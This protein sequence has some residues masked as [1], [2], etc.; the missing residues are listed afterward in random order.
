MNNSVFEQ[1]HSYTKYL[2]LDL[3]AQE[4]ARFSEDQALSDAQLQAIASV[5]SYL[6]DKKEENIVATLLRMSRLP[7]KEP[8]TFENFDFSQLHGK[9][10][11]ALKNLSTLSALY[12]HTNLAFIGPQG[13]GKTHLAMA[14]G[15]ACCERGLKAYFLKAT[16]L[17]QRLTEARRHGRENSC[18]NGLV[19]PSCL[20]IDEIGRCVFDR[21]NTRMFFDIID[22]RYNKEG[23]NTLIL[24][25]NK[26]PDKWGEY[27]N[28][29]SSLLCSLYRI[30]DVAT[31]FVIKGNSYRGKQC[32]T[33]ALTAGEPVSVI[34]SKN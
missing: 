9:D 2:D 20:I 22:R 25:S 33:I 1:I 17:N 28:E 11:E 4:I 21:E 14:Y 7:M 12:S 5:F 23:P 10:A 24:T 29:D 19:K 30:F 32:E 8:K 15:R 31:V 27:F 3:G 26:S 6:R 13:V 34:K 16:E 18:I